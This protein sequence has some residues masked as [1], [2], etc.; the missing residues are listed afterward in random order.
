MLEFLQY[1]YLENP[2]FH[3]YILSFVVILGLIFG[4]FINV[5]GLRLL[6]GE[7]IVL[8]PSKCPKCNT[9]LKWYDNIPVLA[10]LTLGGK[11][12]YCKTNISWQYPIVE[13]MNAALYLLIFLKFEF[14]LA[15]LF[16]WILASC[17][18]VMCITDFREQVIFD[19]VSM[20]L[21]PIGLVFS[22]LNLGKLPENSIN[23]L[24]TNFEISNVFLSSL[25][26]TVLAFVIFEFI[27]LCSKLIIKQRAFGEGDTI[28]AMI[29]GAF[30]GWQVLLLTI[31]LSFIIQAVIT[32]PLIIFKM[33][34]LK[35]K[36]ALFA[37]ATLLLSALIPLFLLRFDIFYNSLWGLILFISVL[38]LAS[39]SALKF[40]KR[41]KELDAYTLLPFG[42]ALIIAGFLAFFFEKYFLAFINL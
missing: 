8:P 23:I 22:F 39:L 29:F 25:T 6:S 15:T 18:V 4:S 9:K 26:A 17:S 34:N 2:L 16:L 32:F 5:V 21:I 27:S 41:M 24:N 1:Q 42:P 20:P 33:L 37:F 12:R 28:I 38:L 10:Y 19:A 7:S 30:F 35:D 14:S 13:A 36:I 31:L 3:Y 11:C 40:L